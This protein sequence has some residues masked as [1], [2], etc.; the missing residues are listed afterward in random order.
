MLH[1][2]EGRGPATLLLIC[3]FNKNP[4]NGGF[5]RYC[6]RARRARLCQCFTPAQAGVQLLILLRFNKKPATRR[7]FCCLK[8]HSSSPLPFCKLRTDSATPRQ[9]SSG[10]ALPKHAPSSRGIPAL[11]HSP[12]GERPTFSC[13]AKR[14][15]AKRR[16]PH[17]R[18]LRTVPVLKVREAAP[19]FADS[20]SVDW[21]RTGPHRMG[22]PTDISCA[23][24][25]RPRGPHQ[26]ASCAPER[27]AESMAEARALEA[28]L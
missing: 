19:G 15:W 17:T 12:P 6:P 8:I 4:P 10:F 9:G 23:A 11:F 20:P 3:L 28:P 22:H 16:P 21:H 18:A 24:S 7:V 13:V 1:P 25:P 27:R 14:K 26:R 2:G 5:F